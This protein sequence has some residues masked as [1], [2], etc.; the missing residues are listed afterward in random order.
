[1]AQLALLTV[2]LFFIAESNASD[3]ADPS[4]LQGF[5]SKY[6]P[7]GS[8]AS[9]SS[10]RHYDKFITP[11]FNRLRPGSGPD[12][13]QHLDVY[14]DHGE[15]AGPDIGSSPF[16]IF[17]HKSAVHPAISMQDSKSSARGK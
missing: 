1:M 5:L 11:N 3:V 15:I 9:K 10:M 6:E 12:A 14:G 4:A 7:F 16:T 2:R 8:D 13:S 17:D